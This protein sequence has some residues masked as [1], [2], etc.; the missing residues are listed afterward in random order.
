MSSKLWT[1]TARARCEPQVGERHRHQVVLALG[2]NLGDRLF[3]LNQAL[4]CL[5][6]AEQCRIATV[7]SV[8]ETDPVGGPDQP[9][10]LNAGALLSTTETPHDLLRRCQRIEAELGRRRLVRWGPRTVDLDLISIDDLEMETAELT[11]PHPRA[12][13]RAFVLLPW[14]DVD[15]EAFLP[16]SGSVRVLAEAAG[17]RAG[18]RPRNDLKLVVP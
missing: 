8:I 10:Y 13:S 2:A 18:V 15:P 14:L 9:A 1:P 12:A 16:G 3:V 5:A 11:L 7:S 17:D 4:R 6:L